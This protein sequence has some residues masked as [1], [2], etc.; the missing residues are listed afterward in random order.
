MQTDLSDGFVMIRRYRLDDIPLNFAAVRES[1][2][3][4]SPWMPWCHENYSVDDAT[5]FI[6]TR[7]AKW[8]NGDEYEFAIF[9]VKDGVFLG[10]VGLNHVDRTDKCANLGYWVRSGWTRRGVASAAVRLI[11]RF[12]LQ[13]L[14]FNRLEIIAAA[15]NQA[16]QRVAEK[17]GAKREGILRKRVWLHG[18]AHDAVMN[19]LV[20]EDFSLVQK[21]LDKFI[22]S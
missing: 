19:S 10:G 13:E 22:P 12:G 1:I 21:P 6:S 2:K 20:A 18:M 8:E 14:G 15:G 11:A 4:L 16:S 9:H 17:A 3:E 7:D 5:D